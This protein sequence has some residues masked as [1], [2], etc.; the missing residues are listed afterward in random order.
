MYQYEDWVDS[1][2]DR[3]YWRALVNSGLNLRVPYATELVCWHYKDSKR[4]SSIIWLNGVQ[5]HKYNRSNKN[6][7]IYGGNRRVT[8][9]IRFAH[10]T[11]VYI[12][13]QAKSSSQTVHAPCHVKHGRFFVAYKKLLD[14][15]LESRANECE[16]KY[17]PLYTKHY[18]LLCSHTVPHFTFSIQSILLQLIA[19]CD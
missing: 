8:A 11:K 10:R 18:I 19:T 4:N 9:I 5:K 2:K 6:K 14:E 15:L 1:T 7:T 13:S 17:T 16:I 12:L 3:D